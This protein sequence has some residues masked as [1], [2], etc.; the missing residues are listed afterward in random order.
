MFLCVF[1][2]Q[3]Y[4]NM[5]LRYSGKCWSRRRQNCRYRTRPPRQ[6]SD[7]LYPKPA[8]DN[9]PLSTSQDLLE[10]LSKNPS[11]L[12]EERIESAKRRAHQVRVKIQQDL[13]KGQ[14]YFVRMLCGT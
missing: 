9:Q 2:T 1:R 14:F 5:P 13:V 6:R 10:E 3:K 11:P 7:A 4:R 8:A 12:L